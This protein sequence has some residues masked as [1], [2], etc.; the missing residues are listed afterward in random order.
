VTQGESAT[1]SLILIGLGANLPSRFGPPRESLD[2]ALQA[3]D[4]RGVSIVRRSRWW[5]SQPVPISDQPWFVN[6]V[7]AVETAL[8]PEDLLAMLHGIE[9]EFGRVRSVVNAARLLDL[10][11]L[12]YGRLI[13]DGAALVCPHPR[14][15]QRAF[16]LMPLADIAAD[17]RDPRDGRDLPTMI[18][19]LPPDQKIEAME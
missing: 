19:A 15:Q 18:A 12:A 13:I 9:A 10:D 1:D 4:R 7:A 6:G 2:A 16:V 14:L 3:L 11:L 8:A 17:W 5:R